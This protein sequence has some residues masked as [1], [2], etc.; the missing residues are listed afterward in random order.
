MKMNGI[1]N[2]SFENI[3][4][5]WKKQMN[6]IDTNVDA[7]ILWTWHGSIHFS[8]GFAKKN[9]RWNTFKESYHRFR[10]NHLF[11][12]F[13]ELQHFPLYQAIQ[14]YLMQQYQLINT[15]RNIQIRQI[16]INLIVKTHLEILEYQIYRDH[17]KNFIKIINILCNIIFLP[18]TTWC[19]IWFRAK[20][21]QL[22]SVR[23]SIQS[24]ENRL[25]NRAVKWCRLMY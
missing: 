10:C 13:P 8:V 7:I 2:K 15:Q 11:L 12:V 17:L 23:R 1:M 24:I 14:R 6:S 5:C 22:R 4:I 25:W 9:D 21:I 18:N 20:M 19:R 3:Y 16:R